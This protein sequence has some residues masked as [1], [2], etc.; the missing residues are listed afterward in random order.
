[1]VEALADLAEDVLRRH[2]DVLERELA[3]VRGVHAH[4]LELARDEKPG[5]H[6][7]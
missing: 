4:L 5:V 1:V 6:R 7:R 2:P 3:G